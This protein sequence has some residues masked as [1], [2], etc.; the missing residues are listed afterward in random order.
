MV[1]HEDSFLGVQVT[2]VGNALA[3]GDELQHEG[4]G[5]DALV[6]RVTNA[7]NEATV[8]QLVMHPVPKV[9]SKAEKVRKVGE[10]GEVLGNGAFTT[11]YA[12]K[13]ETVVIETDFLTT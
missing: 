3:V 5:D 2:K 6:K 10:I 8:H 13:E 7:A 1:D 9:V 4:L 12:P 11:T